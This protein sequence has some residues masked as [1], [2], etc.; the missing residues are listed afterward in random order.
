M[1]P[2]QGLFLKAECIFALQSYAHAAVFYQ[3]ACDM[4]NNPEYKEALDRCIKKQQEDDPKKV[5][6]LHPL[7]TITNTQGLGI[8]FSY[9]SSLFV[10]VSSFLDY[11]FFRLLFKIFRM[12][13]FLHIYSESIVVTLRVIC[14]SSPIGLSEKICFRVQGEFHS[15]PIPREKVHAFT[16]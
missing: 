11:C 1:L 6:N 8:F 7:A 13:A 2:S 14:H 5:F 16:V 10:F 15:P 12:Q 4:S 9:Y 3:R